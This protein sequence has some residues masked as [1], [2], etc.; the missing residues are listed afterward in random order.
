VAG[1]VGGAFCTSLCA[2]FT[3]EWAGTYDG[4]PPFA[5]LVTIHLCA[6]AVASRKRAPRAAGIAAAIALAWT[7]P[8]AFVAYGQFTRPVGELEAPL[9]AGYVVLAFGGIAPV[10]AF[11]GGGLAMQRSCD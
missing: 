4:A 8:V 7:A 10:V 6:L 9:R 2:M 5:I 11:A 3:V 1:A